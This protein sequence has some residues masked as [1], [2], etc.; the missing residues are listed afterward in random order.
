MRRKKFSLVVI[1]VLP[2]GAFNSRRREIEARL[3]SVGEKFPAV[4]LPTEDHEGGWTR[5]FAPSKT[6][7]AYLIDAKRKFAWKHEGVGDP[8]ARVI[9]E[10]LD[11]HLAPAAAP[12][13]RPLRLEIPAGERAPDAIFKD[14]LGEGGALHRMKGEPVLLNFWQAW[15]EPCI[16]E[17]LRLQA[18]QKGR[19][20]EGPAVIAFHGG[21][22]GGRLDEIAKQ[23]GLTFPLVQ[24][25]G[26][27][28]ARRFGVRC[29]P[30]TISLGADG[31]VDHVQFGVPHERGPSGEVK[32][33]E[34]GV[35]QSS[36]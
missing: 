7:A 22:D 6:P 36:P 19:E 1:V 20:G 23:H 29:W 34:E 4:L 18:L 21:E 3:A 26:Q 11:K 31:S 28:I 12:R 2:A 27:R 16:K 24:D 17:L 35:C 8:D 13:S 9:A 15:S 25:T 14:H 5:A 30:T 10:A 33:E 32:A